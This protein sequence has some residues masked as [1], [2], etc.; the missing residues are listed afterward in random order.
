MEK[1]SEQKAQSLKLFDVATILGLNPG[2]GKMALSPE[3]YP[4][5]FQT[6]IFALFPAWHND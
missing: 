6:A 4:L 5:S 2:Y 1:G 3:P